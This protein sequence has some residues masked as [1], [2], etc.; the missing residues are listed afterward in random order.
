MS[1]FEVA[2]VTLAVL[3]L[4]ISAA[5]NYHNVYSRF[6]RFRKFSA[7][8]KEFQSLLKI[9]RTIFREE[10]RLLVGQV[11]GEDEV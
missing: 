5:E 11:A 2:G 1:G 8:V 3:S 9:Q 4:V 10:C 7:E 6:T